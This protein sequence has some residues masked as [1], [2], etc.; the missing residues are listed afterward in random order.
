MCSGTRNYCWS[1]IPHKAAGQFLTDTIPVQPEMLPFQRPQNSLSHKTPVGL[2]NLLR[3]EQPDP[4]EIDETDLLTYLIQAAAVDEEV[5][6]EKK[7]S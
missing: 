1:F 4:S 7:K 6:L 5:R 2:I 3:K